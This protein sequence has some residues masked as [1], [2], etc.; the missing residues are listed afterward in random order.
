M[1]VSES[2]VR[3]YVDVGPEA[4]ATLRARWPGLEVSGVGGH[5]LGVV[6]A[7]G[8]NADGFPDGAA[9]AA[10]DGTCVVVPPSA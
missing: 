10:W 2:D 6:Q 7:V 4:I 5:H 3:A 9:D 1:S 8:Q